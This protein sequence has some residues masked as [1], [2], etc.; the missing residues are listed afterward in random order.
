M[1]A[2]AA[3]KLYVKS[4]VLNTVLEEVPNKLLYHYTDQNGLLG[5]IKTKEIWAT[6]HQCLND[7]QEFLYAKEL[8]RTELKKRI[9]ANDD[10]RPLLEA[11]SLALQGPGN[12]DV[13]LYVASFS[14]E[15][16]SLSQ[17][18]AYG[19]ASSGFALGF[20]CER[21]ILPEAFVLARCI[22]QREK[23]SEVVDAI[24]SEVLGRLKKGGLF[25]AEQIVKIMLLFE[26]HAFALI[27]KHPK[28]AEEREWRIISRVMMDDAP[29]FPIEDAT[30]L[31]FR[32]GKSMLIPYRCISVKDGSGGF[33]LRKVIVGPNPNPEQSR[34]SVRSL[35]NSRIDTKAVEVESS[36]IPYRN[37]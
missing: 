37:W 29:A 17:W 28:F 8:V 27:L 30:R 2:A 14:E 21:L 1:R 23:H 7:T 3:I 11:M 22:Y 26:L 25:P 35:L 36:D 18:R 24:L 9:S 32:V 10:S 4:N 20:Q 34:R 13:N 5:I 31:E 12:E 16:D 6:H 19:G 15:P 33:L